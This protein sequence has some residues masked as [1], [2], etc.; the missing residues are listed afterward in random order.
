MDLENN[1]NEPAGIEASKLSG[2]PAFKTNYVT[3]ESRLKTFEHAIQLV[4]PNRL[5]EAGFFLVSRE[6]SHNQPTTSVA[7]AQTEQTEIEKIANVLP[8]LHHIKC[9]FCPFE[10]LFL[11]NSHINP[12][13]KSAFD[14]HRK[15]FGHICPTM[16]VKAHS[17]AFTE[18]QV[19]LETFRKWPA[20][21][22]QQPT[23]LAKAGFFYDR[24]DSVK[25]FVCNG[26]LD[27]WDHNDC[28]YEEHAR[29]FPKCHFIRQLMGDEYIEKIREKFKNEESG[30]I[31]NGTLDNVTTNSMLSSF[32]AATGSLKSLVEGEFYR[33]SSGAKKRSMSPRSLQLCTHKIKKLVDSSIP[34]LFSIKPSVD[35]KLCSTL[36]IKATRPNTSVAATKTDANSAD[37]FKNASETFKNA[38]ETFKNATET[39]KNATETFKNATDTLKS[40]GTL[41]NNSNQCLMVLLE[42]KDRLKNERRCHICLDN[43]K[44]VLF[45]PCAHFVSCLQCS[46][47]LNSCP[48][49]LVEVNSRIKVFG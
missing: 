39:F 3:I 44:K 49:C 11:R 19:R 1:S 41:N 24:N 14:E 43:E 27:K 36:D 34:N 21:L 23:D 10:C 45:L 8:Y 29:W 4:D 46:Q 22:I 37:T 9:A 5:A 17:P 13:Y 30:C 32:Q 12:L 20:T 18:L 16:I 35:I 7:S 2:E 42:E 47:M 33:T 26:S 48:I 40:R 38:T 25:C 6:T 31:N 15:T 28:P